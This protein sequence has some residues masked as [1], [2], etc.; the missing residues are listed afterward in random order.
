MINLTLTI[1]GVSYVPEIPPNLVVDKKEA[2]DYGEIVIK[3][4]T[5]ENP[6]DEGAGVVIVVDGVTFEYRVDT[7]I[8]VQINEG[9]FNHTVTLIEPTAK[10]T[11]YI[12]ADRFMT[13]NSDGTP[14]TYKQHLEL[15]RN[16]PLN[17]TKAFSIPTATSNF[18]DTTAVQKKYVNMNQLQSLTDL[19]RSKDAV[20]RLKLNGDLEYTLYNEKNQ[21]ITI[22]ELTGQTKRKDLNNFALSVRSKAKNLVYDGD[23]QTAATF[24]PTKDEGVKP[25]TD[26]QYSDEKARYIL[27]EN[28]RRM[29]GVTIIDCPLSGSRTTDLPIGKYVVSKEEWDSLELGSNDMS[30]LQASGKKQRNTLYYTIGDNEV[31]NMATNWK[32]D[33]GLFSDDTMEALIKSAL[34]DSTLYTPADYTSGDIKDYK[35]N[36][37][38]QPYFDGDLT[39]Q[40][41]SGVSKRAEVLTNQKDS[42]VDLGRYSNVLKGTISRLSNGEYTITKKHDSMADTFNLGDYTADNF[43]VTKISYEIYPNHINATYELTKNFIN[44][45]LETSV[46]NRPTPFTIERN[47]V[48]TNFVYT[49][50]IEISDTKRLISSSMTQDGVNSFMNGMD[51]LLAHDTPIYLSHYYSAE[52]TSIT[53]T[54]SRIHRSALCVGDSTGVRLFTGFTHPSIAG[55]RNITESDGGGTVQAS[56]PVRYTDA[57]GGI[58]NAKYEF[59]NDAPFTESSFPLV[60]A[61]SNPLIETPSIQFDLQPNEIKGFTNEHLFYSDERIIFG[62][63]LGQENSLVKLITVP[64]T[65]LIYISAS[66]TVY[67]IYDK[68]IKEATDSSINFTVDKIDRSVDVS[69]ISETASVTWALGDSDGNLYFAVNYDG[70]PLQKVY[71]NFLKNRVGIS[72]L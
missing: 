59:Y 58:V 22:G 4:T 25:R 51:Y 49:E 19:F 67:N 24:Y 37:F 21:P 52:S 18:L 40:R 68:Q 23:L 44:L 12:T 31:V 28:I 10:L 15:L 71:F 64:K 7:D 6:F 72:D 30:V 47:N 11:K 62:D 16:A 61:S 45:D 32:N 69:S 36:F 33:T 60:S 65:M 57:G 5:V 1:D 63:K 29:I 46:T 13:V 55:L 43:Q 50:F 39:A 42:I 70:T 38:F 17:G 14:M 27:D 54:S 53:S 2:F 3:H 20:P 48:N 35:L 9:V 8:V 26:G 56:Q 34:F 41:K 66:D